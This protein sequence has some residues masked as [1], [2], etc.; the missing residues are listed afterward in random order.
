[1]RARVDGQLVLNNL[2]LKVSA[3][4]AGM[5]LAYP[6]EDQVA[7]HVGEGRLVRALDDWC[8]PFSGYH[9]YCP[10]RRQ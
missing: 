6:P 4:L 2:D 5:G 10:S 1:M 8:A 3:V 9:L 7:L